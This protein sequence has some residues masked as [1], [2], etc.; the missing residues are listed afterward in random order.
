MRREFDRPGPLRTV[1]AVVKI[2]L[3][4]LLIASLVFSD[5]VRDVL[6]PS[7]PVFAPGG[8]PGRP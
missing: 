1:A 4:L 6:S 2:A 8:A 5:G 7:G 3:I